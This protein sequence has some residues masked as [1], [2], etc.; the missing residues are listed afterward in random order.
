MKHLGL[1]A[2]LFGTSVAVTSSAIGTERA[3]AATTPTYLTIDLATG[4]SIGK[5]GIEYDRPARDPWGG[6]DDTVHWTDAGEIFEANH[7]LG[8]TFLQPRGVVA[9]VPIDPSSTWVR[10]EAYPRNTRSCP[11]TDWESYWQSDCYWSNYSMS[12]DYF[13]GFHMWVHPDENQD[14]PDIGRLDVPHI[15]D[16][17]GAFFAEG[18]IISPDP[19]DDGRLRIDVFQIDCYFTE[20]CIHPPTTS[21]GLT[22]GSFAS[23][24][25]TGDAWTMGVSWPG[26]YM[27]VIEDTVTRAKIQALTD[28]TADSVPSIDLGV[29]CFGFLTCV[30]VSGP[31]A[32]DAQLSTFHPT[33]PT[34]ILDT[35]TGLGIPN[36]PVRAGDGSID[37]TNDDLRTDE[38]LNHEFVV[39]GVAGVPTTGVSAVLLNVTAVAPVGSGY[40]SIGPRPQGSGDI[41]DDQNSYGDWPTSSNL[42][43]VSGKS[44]PNMVLARVGA[45][46]RVR[47]HVRG[48]T[49][50]IIADVA[51]WFGYSQDDIG[52]AGY[53]GVTPVRAYDSRG[54]SRG[55]FGPRETRSIVLNERFGIPD[56]AESV[57]L[58]LTAVNPQ[59]KGYV[60]ASPSGSSTPNASNLNLIPGET[61][62]NLAVVS[63][64]ADR[65]IDL[66]SFAYDGESTTHLIVDVFGYYSTQSTAR[67][68]A[69]A[70]FRVLDTRSG[71]GTT[72]SP[73]TPSERRRL[74]IAGAGRV[75]R[76]ATAV[77]LN[78]TV[79]A[80]TAPGYLTAAPA[81]AEMPYVS[82]VNWAAGDTN[83]NMAVIPLGVDGSIDIEV[84]MQL[85]GSG[86]AD[87]LVDVLGWVTDNQ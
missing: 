75:P 38:E 11:L 50:H 87:V 42:N 43:V 12:N 70:P 37:T 8:P 2:V 27:L 85:G 1:A 76:G 79:V 52:A 86:T 67:S 15:G 17:K 34:R 83:P 33:P 84:S 39:T 64:G 66:T 44:V 30:T 9:G 45:G 63:L 10:L 77:Y 72:A 69:P 5:I 18:S 68:I 60:T 28:V 19:V 71:L 25:S 35:R 55:R 47:L 82:N 24:R 54:D 58:N 21:T 3:H 61:R 56:D 48:T 16:D 80:P 23:G 41:F 57:V 14:W 31:T 20:V 46:G 6:Y 74:T 78:I 59:G 81:G 51:G 32:P 36:G 40:I 73:F 13:G 26:R 49:T 65:S 4:G 53:E 62:P 29:P 22:Y 7:E